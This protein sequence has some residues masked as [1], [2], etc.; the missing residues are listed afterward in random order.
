MQMDTIFNFI[1]PVAILFLSYLFVAIVQAVRKRKENKNL[2][3]ALF[4][5]L[6]NISGLKASEIEKK[7]F[8]PLHNHVARQKM[9]SEILELFDGD[10]DLETEFHLTLSM[11]D[12]NYPV[13]HNTELF[14]LTIAIVIVL[15]LSVNMNYYHL[16]ESCSDFFRFEHKYYDYKYESFEECIYDFK[17]TPLLNLERYE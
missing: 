17:G 2:V 8:D 16:V 12:R 9:I 7:L 3:D 5:D 1:G 10:Q 15:S 13:N 11:I 6:S 14:L 4:R